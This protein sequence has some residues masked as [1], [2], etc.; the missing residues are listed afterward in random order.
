MW[1]GVQLDCLRTLISCKCMSFCDIT[2][3]LTFFVCLF[4]QWICKIEK[5][6]LGMSIGNVWLWSC[7]LFCGRSNLCL[8]EEVFSVPVLD[9]L[10]K[11]WRDHI[12]VHWWTLQVPLPSAQGKLLF[13]HHHHWVLPFS[14]L[15]LWLKDSSET[16]RFFDTVKP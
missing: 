2:N 16:W 4:L 7:A 13:H 1:Q 6:H 14:D 8:K 5:H 3:Y 12:P 9:W 15:K 11:I 10:Q